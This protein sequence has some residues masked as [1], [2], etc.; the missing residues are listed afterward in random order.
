MIKTGK[1]VILILNEGR[2]R[3]INEIE[4][5]A[6]AIVDVYLPSNYGADALADIIAGSVNPSGKLPITY[7]RHTNDLVPYIHKPSE[8]GGN[9]Q[10]GMFRPQFPFGFG[11]SYTTFAY[12]NLSVNKSSFGPDETATISVTVKNTG[13]SK[14]KEVVEL[15][16]SDLIASFTPDVQRLRGFE[17]IELNPGESKTVSF[18]IPMKQLA[19]VGPDNKHHLEAGGFKAQVADQSTVFEVTKTVAF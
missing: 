12:S 7:P 9:P 16:I 15:F 10:G 5:G 13:Y 17:K 14:G 2:P 4:P 11:L 8:G 18:K 6:A 19:Y 1:P 3:I